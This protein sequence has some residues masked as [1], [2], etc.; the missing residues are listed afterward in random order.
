MATLWKNV[1]CDCELSPHSDTSSTSD[2][3]DGIY[4]LS[5]EALLTYFEEYVLSVYLVSPLYIDKSSSACLPSLMIVFLISS[6]L[7]VILHLKGLGRILSPL[8][9]L[10]AAEKY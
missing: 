10:L 4:H 3:L 1:L 7:G 8:L 5:W 6:L 2:L 9:V